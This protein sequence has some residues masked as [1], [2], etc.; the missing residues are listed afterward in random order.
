MHAIWV[1]G[2]VDEE[3]EVMELIQLLMLLACTYW[4]GSDVKAAAEIIAKAIR[5]SK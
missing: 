2:A 3:G 4:L 5:E 1:G